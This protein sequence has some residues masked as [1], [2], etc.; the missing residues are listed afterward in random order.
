[1][2]TLKQLIPILLVLLMGGLQAVEVSATLSTDSVAAGEGALLTLSVTDGRPSGEPVI[3]PV[4]DLIVNSRGTSQNIQI[5]NGA[6]TRSLSYTYVV[7][8]NQEGEYEVPAIKVRVGG[9]EYSTQPLKLRVR[10][11]ADAKPQGIDDENG[12]DEATEEAGDYGHLTLQMVEKDRTHVYPG[13]IA[14]VRI[15]AFFPADAQVSLKGA[16]R[17]EGSAFTLHNLSEEPDQSSVTI[18][19]KRY[20]V[21][22]WFGGLSATKAGTY[23]AIIK[24][25]GTVSVPDRSASRR[26]PFG[27]RGSPFDDPFFSGSMFGD[28]F[29]QMIEKD[30]ELTTD[31]EDSEIEVIE[32]PQEGR[33]ENFTGAIGNFEFESAQIPSSLAT[34]EPCRIEAVLKGQ[35]NF[36]LLTEPKPMPEA[37]WKSYDGK[38][39]FEGGDVASFAGRKSFR[40]SA[41]PLTPGEKE[42]ALSFSYFDPDA[43]EYV[44]VKSPSQQVTITGEVVANKSPSKEAQPVE[45]TPEVPQLAPLALEAGGKGS[46]LPLS[47]QAWFVPVLALCGILSAGILGY[48]WWTQ[49]MA[50]PSKLSR[51]ELDQ[52]TQSALTNAG[53]AVSA[54]NAPAFFQAAREAMRLRVAEARGINPEAVT[55]ADLDGVDDET[56]ATI[57]TEADRVEYSGRSGG[58]EDL[59]GWQNKLDAAMIALELNGKGKTT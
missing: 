21:V 34:G 39:D 48:G 9:R 53:K 54:G 5:I 29:G 36:S 41:V 22:T 52:A 2:V 32:L 31:A 35:G 20:L 43:G 14:P 38:S 26:S 57:F 19:G 12:E 10:A 49:R 46:Y 45:Q 8:S 58:S 24:L 47:E 7:G 59:T 56:V 27:G 55:A 11:A 18:D 13:E 40:Y 28:I 15:R 23:P 4:K 16:P 37:E 25:D 50:D 3:P 42:V 51:L 6:M 44:E 1:M 30:I 33:P 17:P